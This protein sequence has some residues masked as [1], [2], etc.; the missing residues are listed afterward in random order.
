[1]NIRHQLV[2]IRFDSDS[3]ITSSHD[4]TGIQIRGDSGSTIVLQQSRP[5]NRKGTT[6]GCAAFGQTT[7]EIFADDDML[8]QWEAPGDSG[9]QAVVQP[10]QLELLTRGL[11]HNRTSDGLLEIVTDVDAHMMITV[12][13]KDGLHCLRGR[14]L[15]LEILHSTHSSGNLS[16]T[17]PR[18]CGNCYMEE[19]DFSASE[20]NK[21][22]SLASFKH[23]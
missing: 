5:C 6:L 8:V 21:C 23:R 13:M 19:C 4:L 17:N 18:K 11:K 12:E 3:Q 10:L 22:C 7:V 16:I 1:M 2:V 20:P 9:N 14:K 15:L